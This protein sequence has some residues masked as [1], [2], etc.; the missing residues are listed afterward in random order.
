MLNHDNYTEIL[1]VLEKTMQDVLKAKEVPASNEKQ[2][3]WATNHTLEGAQNL[4][5]AF[6]DK[7][8][9]WSEVGV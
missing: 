3:G 5:R 8:T 4:A 6:L 7:R 2:C 9:E 1:E